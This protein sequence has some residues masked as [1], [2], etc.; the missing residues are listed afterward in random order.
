MADYNKIIT[1]VNSITPDYEFIP[2]LNNTIVIDTS[3]NRIGIN[4]ITPDVSIHV[5]GGTIK[6]K[7]V[8]ILNDLSV[9]NFSSNLIPRD[10][11]SYNIGNIDYRFNDL[12]VGSNIYIDKTPILKMGDYTRGGLDVSALIINNAGSYLDISDIIQVN[13]TGDVSINKNLD[14]TG[15]LRS[16]SDVS[17]S[18][19][20]F[21]IDN[22]TSFNNTVNISGL[23]TC[24][25]DVSFLGKLLVTEDA[26][27]NSDVEISGTLF[28]NH[29]FRDDDNDLSSTSTRIY[30]DRV[31]IDGEY[32]TRLTIDPANYGERTT[33]LGYGHVVIDGNLFVKGNTT[34]ISSTNVDISDN[35]IRMNAN[36]FGH[37]SSEDM[38]KNGGIAVITNKVPVAGTHEVKHF[39]YYND[40]K[41]EDFAAGDGNDFSGNFWD[42]DDTN[43]NLNTAGITASSFMYIGNIELRLNTINT[44]DGNLVIKASGDIDIE[45]ST[46]LSGDST[47]T[48]TGATTLNSDFTVLGASNLASLTVAGATT[49]NTLTVVGATTSNTLTVAGETKSAS[50]TVAAATT[51]ASLEVTGPTTL[52]N[53][54]VS[55]WNGR[56]SGKIRFIDATG[57]EDDSMIQHFP[58]V[59]EHYKLDFIVGKSRALR[60][61]R[62]GQ[63]SD[64]TIQDN[65]T[66]VE[67]EEYTSAVAGTG[68]RYQGS[69]TPP[70]YINLGQK[71]YDLEA[72][73]EVLEAQGVAALTT[74]VTALTTS[75]SDLSGAWHGFADGSTGSVMRTVLDSKVYDGAK[76]ALTPEGQN[77]CGGSKGCRSVTDFKQ[78]DKDT[79]E[80]Q[81]GWRKLDGLWGHGEGGK[82]RIYMNRS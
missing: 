59:F 22:D 19:S 6:S 82:I 8:I 76:I 45:S 31:T 17:F 27:F 79:D 15:N 33:G 1:T 43:L 18:G 77:G 49:S 4:T 35:I 7:D 20:K 12:F 28:I 70:T 38:V 80:I 39:T 73:I 26:S 63:H 11:N 14:I 69:D 58:V 2:N 60:L 25:N 34:Y 56:D 46:I 41:Y 54:T 36:H 5:S 42:T 47:L 48:V 40:G 68:G 30:T 16:L 74:S 61:G 3:E 50:L 10:D 65:K 53:L 62:C 71:L 64:G 9:N 67:I 51:S 78:V 21:Y 55:G 29:K 72:R 24:L 75:V 37:K 13:I 52:Q 32:H 66:Y 57:L 81:S 23:L 44:T